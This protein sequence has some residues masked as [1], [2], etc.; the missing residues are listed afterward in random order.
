MSSKEVTVEHLLGNGSNYAIW[1]AC[2]LNAFKII[3][4]HFERV[5]IR[6]S[7]LLKLVETHLRRN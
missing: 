4:P 6:V 7:C 3:R 1:F 5:F 2:I